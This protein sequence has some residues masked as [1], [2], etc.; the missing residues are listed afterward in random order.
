M[1]KTVIDHALAL[2]GRG[3]PVFPCQQ[4]KKP[5]I[6]GGFHKASTDEN[7]IRAWWREFPDALMGVPVGAK[8][9]VLD[10]DLQHREALAWYSNANLPLT[11]THITR[12]GGRHLLFRPHPDF[13]HSA[14]KICRG[15]DT[16]CT[17]G[18]VIWW[19]AHGFEALHCGNAA[20]LPE[21]LLKQMIKANPAPW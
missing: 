20:E 15:V 14:G 4:D 17:G 12:S 13:K 5:Y 8:F 2:A 6:K 10:L 3:L 11:R 1:P 7:V 21:W 18:Y 16:R 9:V 19:P